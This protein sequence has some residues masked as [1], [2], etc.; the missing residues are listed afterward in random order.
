MTT[1]ALSPQAAGF[2]P[3]ITE[4]I[5]RTSG[6][7]GGKPR[8]AGH[9]IKVVHVARWH[10]RMG[11]SPAQIVADHP[12]ITLADVHAALAYYHD[13]RA[14]IDADIQAADEAFER[15]KSQQPSL[16]EKIAAQRPDTRSLS[17][18]AAL[19]YL[20]SGHCP[21]EDVERLRADLPR[22]LAQAPADP[23]L[24][25]LREELGPADQG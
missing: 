15:L 8:I 18:A 7:C 21:A 3:V 22:R 17:A 13:H 4:H 12:G 6:V 19:A 5:V 14:E 2:V 24:A 23:D 16:L 25:E 11:Q 1:H 20:R 9:R 10:E